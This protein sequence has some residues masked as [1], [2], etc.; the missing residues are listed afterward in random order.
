MDVQRAPVFRSTPA[1]GSAGCKCQQSFHGGGV[2]PSVHS[3]CGAVVPYVKSPNISHHSARK[4]RTHE[5][6]LLT[7]PRAPSPGNLQSALR[8][9]GFA[10]SGRCRHL[11]S[12]GDSCMWLPP[13]SLMLSRF[14]HDVAR[15]RTSLLCMA[16]HYSTEWMVYPST[17]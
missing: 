12:Y 7:P 2:K 16:D 14:S 17:G 11:E 3:Q 8:L 10:Y 6:S 5:Q 1:L 4:S 9:H 15:T 13:P